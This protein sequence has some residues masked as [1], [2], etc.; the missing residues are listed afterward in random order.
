A[1]CEQMDDPAQ[2]KGLVKSDVIRVVSPGTRLDPEALDAKA[3]N[4]THAAAPNNADGTVDWATV[5]F[6]TGKFWFGRAASQSDWL[7]HV[8]AQAPAETLFPDSPA[9]ESLLLT[10][11]EAMPRS[12]AQTAPGFYFDSA[13]AAERIREQFQVSHLAAVHPALA[14][15]E[16]AS[17]ALIK[18]FQETQKAPRI[19]SAMRIELWALDTAM[20]LDAATVRALELFPARAGHGLGSTRDVSLLS[21]LDRTKTAMGGRLL[22]DWILRP[23]TVHMQIEERLDQVEHLLSGHERLA[24]ALN[25]IYD[26]ERLLSRISLGS[27]AMAGARELLAL[28]G[29]IAKSGELAALTTEKNLR[30]KLTAALDPK[31]VELSKLTL[32]VLVEK[33][34]ATT[35]EGGMFRK[36][37]RADLDELIELSENG[38]QWLA[39]FEAR[40]RKAT[41]INSLKVRFNR[42][43]GY[44]LE[45]TKANLD[46]APKHYIRKQTMVGGERYITEELKQFEEKILTAEKKRCDLEHALFRELCAKFAELSGPITEVARAVAQV[47][48][49]CALAAVA[50]EE[51]YTRPRLNDSTELE[52]IEGRHPTVAVA[53]AKQK[54]SFVPNTVKLG[55]RGRFLLIT[56]PNMGGKSTVMRQTALIILLAQLG[57]FVPAQAANIGV[58]DQIFTRIGASDN[59]ADGASTFMVEMSE[60]S[61]ILRHATDRSLILIDEVGRGTSTYDGMSLAW[62]L[63]ADICERIGARTLFATHYHELT[64]LAAQ[65]KGVANARVAVAHDGNSIRFLYRLEPGVAERSYGILVARLAGLPDAVLITAEAMLAQLESQSRK[66]K[67]PTDTNQ[68]ALR[69]DRPRTGESNTSLATQPRPSPIENWLTALELDNLTPMQAMAQLAQWKQKIEK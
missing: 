48:V 29:S 69:L 46:A 22:R 43:F 36:G 67:T 58:V 32:D 14:G 59:I 24:P 62:A 39:G 31:L 51:G 41:G 7:A 50:S 11:R 4:Y 25:E 16:G 63:A 65:Y 66:P 68:L 17:G 54:A 49:I 53:M 10:W 12:F 33:P 45:I 35:R 38:E 28:A 64:Q 34:P 23:L 42:V 9:G 61:F 44:Y 18:Y 3:P 52:I 19:P 27:G 57:S 13:Y 1:I 37:H 6:T 20:E 30:A 21:W 5:D 60:M 26:L 47:D 15:R 55:A 40:E 56:G 8:M 2:A